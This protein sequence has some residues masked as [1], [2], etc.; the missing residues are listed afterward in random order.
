MAI[1]DGAVGDLVEELGRLPGIGPKSAQRLA[2]HL[3]TVDAAEAQ[4]LAQAILSVKDKVRA[5][6]VCF[7]IAEEERCR[8]CRD[9]RRDD[10]LLCVVCE[11]RDIVALERTGEFRGRYHVVGGPLSPIDGVYPEHLH[12][13]ELKAR[14]GDGTVTEVVLA[15]SPNH[16]GDATA[17]YVAR[18]LK[19]LGVRVTRLASGL[20][21]GGDLDYADE[22]TLGRA[23][24]GRLAV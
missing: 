11:S 10:A 13:A 6:A 8:I 22:V 12:V 24:N 23:L 16:S 3:L 20:P 17:D 7:N 18:E 15:T 21:V 4:R 1:F 14:L 2:F 9:P 19:P 5:C